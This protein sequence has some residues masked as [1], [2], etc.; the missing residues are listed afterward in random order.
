MYCQHCGKQLVDG[1]AFCPFCGKT[2]SNRNVPQGGTGYNAGTT[3]LTGG[4]NVG[5][6]SPIGGNGA[7][8]T[9]PVGGNGE[10]MTSRL[11]G[12]GAGTT[13]PF[14]GYGAGTSSTT[15]GYNAGMQTPGGGS[16]AGYTPPV[17]QTWIP[18]WKRFPDAIQA[19]NGTWLG[20]KWFKFF[21]YV[22]LILFPFISLVF[23]ISE[24]RRFS[25]SYISASDKRL[26]PVI[27]IYVLVLVAIGVQ[28]YYAQYLLRKW[29]WKG[30]II[31]FRMMY[32]YIGVSVL[33][34]IVLTAMA[35]RTPET[36]AGQILS[37]IRMVVCVLINREYFKN[38][39]FCFYG[40]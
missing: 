5:T 6:T 34:F 1:G 18:P 2:N 24:F 15:G 39:R 28:L 35:G 32:V 36:A 12:N 17:G 3:P 11:V 37:T 14:G 16:N 4:Y 13:P 40:M 33:Y 38:R 26:Q 22:H 27:I 7:G 9:S 10:G 30:T 8:T 29:Q 31:Y 19:P 20:L 23:P 25:S 21:I